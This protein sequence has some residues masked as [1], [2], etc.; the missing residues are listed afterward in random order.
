MGSQRTG[1]C[2]PICS[3]ALAAAEA[4]GK[5]TRGRRAARARGPVLACT[6]L[7]LGSSTMRT[8]SLL[9]VIALAAAAAPAQQLVLPD[10]HHLCESAT[11]LGNTGATTWWRTTG[12]RFQ[13]LYEASHFLGKTGCNGPILITKLRFRGEDGEQ[14]NGG[15][16]YTGVSVQIGSTS[17]T[18]VNM[19]ATF[20]TN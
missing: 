11:Q 15:Q 7:L 8:S 2:M 12:G 14:N 20:A 9:F 17:L 1:A 6:H 10:N 18:N 4:V 16:V 13:V 3:C 19:S 5:C